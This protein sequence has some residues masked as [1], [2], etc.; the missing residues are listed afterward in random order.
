MTAEPGRPGSSRED[1]RAATRKHI[2]G[3]TLLLV[4]RGISLLVNFAVQVF[5]VRYLSKSDYGAFAY[6][7]AIA[8]T[9]ANVILLGLG[10]AISR[11]APMYE[12][13]RDYGALY[14]TLFLAGGIVLGLGVAVVA[15][16][17]ALSGV[18]VEPSVNDPLAASLLLVLIALAPVQALE[19][20]GESVL[21]AFARPVA[22][23]FRRFV[24]G[25]VLKL[26][27]VLFIVLADGDV[28][29]LSYAYVVAGAVSV[30]LYGPILRTAFSRRGLLAH[31]VRREIRYPV[32]EVLAFGLPLFF[33]DVVH[34]ARTTL[35]VIVLEAVRST[36][37]VAD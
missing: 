23:F 29:M 10:R 18:L 13:K 33:S 31:L 30:A 12:E 35:V 36:T 6:A 2:R 37:E 8:S 32:R 20:L 19:S 21:A 28:R 5:T 3:S 17:N 16:A 11:I 22:V 14:G 7:F 26:L 24:L 25:P 15:G 27:A 4:G 34:V 9:M 1:A